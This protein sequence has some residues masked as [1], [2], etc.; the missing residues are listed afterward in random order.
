[1]IQVRDHFPGRHT[2][3]HTCGYSVYLP[4]S[5]GMYMYV[6]GSEHIL[7]DMSVSVVGQVDIT[8]DMSTSVTC[9]LYILRW[10]VSLWLV[11]TYSHAECTEYNYLTHFHTV[12]YTHLHR[13]C[14]NL[15]LL[16]RWPSHPPN[17]GI[18]MQASENTDSCMNFTVLWGV[19]LCILAHRCEHFR[20]TCCFFLQG[21][22]AS[23]HRKTQ[24]SN[25]PLWKLKSQIMTCFRKHITQFTKHILQFLWLSKWWWWRFC[26]LW[27]MTL[28]HCAFISQKPWIFKNFLLKNLK[29]S[30]ILRVLAL[31]RRQN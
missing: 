9:P 12:E 30:K 26:V 19:M 13:P 24:F 29:I 25:S 8:N 5:M 28:F 11:L 20:G 7:H 22:Q 18:L 3:W 27:N 1:M 31:F 15:S 10:W 21:N 4:H 23:H 16:L 6:F 14:C 2:T 17:Q